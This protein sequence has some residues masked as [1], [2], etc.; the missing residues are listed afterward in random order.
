MKA[1]DRR[2]RRLEQQLGPKVDEEDLRLGAILV[3]RARKRA[4]AEGKVFVPPPTTSL[5]ELMY[6]RVQRERAERWRLA[7]AKRPAVADSRSCEPPWSPP[8]VKFS[9]R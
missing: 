1:I 3:E 4:G 6:G 2:L 5:T 9:Y 8:A 7:A